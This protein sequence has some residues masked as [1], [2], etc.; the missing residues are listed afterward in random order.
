[1]RNREALRKL[2]FY[3][4]VLGSSITTSFGMKIQKLISELFEGYGSTTSGIDIEYI[5]AI[6]G[7][8]VLSIKIR[9]KYN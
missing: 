1:M 3:Q 2:L 9:S 8:K 6:D 4:R 5:D 7:K